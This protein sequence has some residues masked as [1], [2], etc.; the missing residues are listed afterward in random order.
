MLVIGIVFLIYTI[1]INN[2]SLVKLFLEINLKKMSREKYQELTQDEL[3][4]KIE[5]LEGK[6]VD[7]KKETKTTKSESSKTIEN[8][9]NQIDELKRSNEKKDNEDFLRDKKFN[10][11]EEKKVYEEK[12]NKWYSKEDAYTIA[13]LDSKKQEKNQED[14]KSNELDGDDVVSGEK[15]ISMTKLANLSSEEYNKARDDIDAWK[16]KLVNEK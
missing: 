1:K 8:L 3:L 13:T 7:Y 6:I 4:D 9:Q 15:T 5:E 11:D 14:I 12:V 10:S 2:W 16:I